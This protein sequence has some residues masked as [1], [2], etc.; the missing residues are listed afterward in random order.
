MSE[1]FQQDPH[2]SVN[3][4]DVNN[5]MNISKAVGKTKGRVS[6]TALALQ[7]TLRERQVIKEKKVHVNFSN[8]LN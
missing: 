8:S 3:K 6:V 5:L 1:P 2:D 7:E 4:E